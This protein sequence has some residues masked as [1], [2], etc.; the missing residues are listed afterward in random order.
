MFLFFFIFKQSNENV[1]MYEDIQLPHT[2]KEKYCHLNH[3]R[4]GCKLY[5]ISVCIDHSEPDFQ[6]S[7]QRLLFNCRE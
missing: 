4:L 7:F 2:E 5:M 3:A 1:Q 6:R